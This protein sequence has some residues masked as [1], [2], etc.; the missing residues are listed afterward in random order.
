MN[1]NF[2]PL[3]CSPVKTK[4]YILIIFVFLGLAGQ[5]VISWICHP[6]YQSV[7]VEEDAQKNEKKGELEKDKFFELSLIESGS[8][9]YFTFTSILKIDFHTSLYCSLPERP[10]KQA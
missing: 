2:T 4:F 8:L 6:K 7:L 5:S 1:I 9:I 10:P 3:F